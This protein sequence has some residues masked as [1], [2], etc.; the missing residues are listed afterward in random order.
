MTEKLKPWCPNAVTMMALA[1]GV[2]SM[3]MALWGKWDMAVV[4]ILLSGFFDFMDGKVA[5][6]LG[7]SSR[8]GA[9][10]DSL[11][12][13]VSFGVA[14]GFL[15]YNWTMNEGLRMEAL[16]D[17]AYRSDAIGLHWGVVLFLAVC[18]ASRLARFNTMLDEKQPA[19]W[20]HFFMGVPAPAGAGLALLPLILWMACNE[21]VELFRNPIIATCFVIFAGVMMA[22]K[23]P[24]ISLKHL[25]PGKKMRSVLMFAM[26]A[27]IAGIISTPWATMAV[28][29]VLY[30]MSIP[31]CVWVFLKLK[32]VSAQ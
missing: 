4:F 28:L 22:S 19:Y 11:S 31:V 20:T 12:D 27:F 23:I 16:K 13:F 30:L 5:R 25:H 6:L 1:C 14:P 18:C 2:S 26:F 10:L 24:T 17:I 9:E 8:F 7:V 15:M 32:K 21:K 3:N 29:G